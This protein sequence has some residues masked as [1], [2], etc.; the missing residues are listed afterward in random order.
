MYLQNRDVELERKKER[1]KK[2]AKKKRKEK[3]KK[4]RTHIIQI[5][6]SKL[7]Y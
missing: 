4:Q 3:Q 7:Q 6:V 5:R 1:H 2:E